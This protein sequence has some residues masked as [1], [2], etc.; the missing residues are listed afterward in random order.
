MFN[1]YID[2]SQSK[3]MMLPNL[4]PSTKKISLRLPE[5]VI[6][7]LKVLAN[8]RDISYQSLLKIYLSEKIDQQLHSH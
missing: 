3:K 8:K 6:E 5:M 1:K 4:K 2:W 7:E